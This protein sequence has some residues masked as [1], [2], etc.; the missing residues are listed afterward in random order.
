M[1]RKAD[2]RRDPQGPPAGRAAFHGG[3]FTPTPPL[4]LDENYSDENRGYPLDRIYAELLQS[5]FVE[6]A[7]L[8]VPGMYLECTWP[9]GMAYRWNGFLPIPVLSI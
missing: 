8:N 7:F 6:L 9:E 1:K 3:I 5:S 2:R 4:P